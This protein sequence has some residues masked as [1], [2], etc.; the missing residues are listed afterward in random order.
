MTEYWIWLTMH[1]NVSGGSIRRLLRRFGT[2]EAVFHAD[3]DELRHTEGLTPGEYQALIS[4]DTAQA[5]QILELCYRKDIHILTYQDSAYPSALRAIDDPPA[6]LYYRGRLPDFDGRPAVA[7]VGAR[8]ASAY[9]LSAAKRI[10]YQLGKCGAIVVSGMARGIDA[11]AMQGAL[12][13]GNPV[14]GVLGCGVDVVYPQENRSLFDDVIHNG[15]LLSEY[16]PGT[17]PLGRNFP[18]RNRIISGLSN[19]VL[20][21][22]AAAKSGALITAG[23]ALDQGR[24]VFAVPGNIGNAACAGSNGLLKQGAMLAESGWDIVSQ[25]EHL[26]P[27]TVTPFDG[28]IQPVQE[29]DLLEAGKKVASYVALPTKQDKIEVDKGSEDHYIDLT[30]IKNQ[31]SEDEWSVLQTLQNGQKQADE[32]IAE[33]GLPAARVL[34]AITLLEVKGYLNRL[35]GKRFSLK[36]N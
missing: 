14:V 15:C 26:Y 33:S 20:V 36:S 25:Y 5:R 12:S 19:A 3:K 4:H 24:D 6:L 9:G 17:P 13:A 11:M 34:A 21:V 30:E 28:G 29:A 1:Q 10:G 7:V 22:E 16:A 32:M 23:L 2:P 35:P 8:N 31:V 18:V 27:Q